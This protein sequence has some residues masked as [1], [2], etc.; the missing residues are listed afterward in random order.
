MIAHLWKLIWNRKRA[1]A[2][3]LTELLAAFLVLAGLATAGAYYLRNY[4]APLGYALEDIWAVEV[5]HGISRWEGT[6]REAVIEAQTATRQLLQTVR[7]LPD[8]VAVAGA[9]TGPILRGMRN[10]ETGDGDDMPPLGQNLERDVDSVTQDFDQVFGLTLLRGRWF[11][12]QDDGAGFRPIVINE[13]MARDYFGDQDPLGQR[14]GTTGGRRGERLPIRVIG[15]VAGYRQKGELAPPV[16]YQFFRYEPEAEFQLPYHKLFVKT[17]PGAGVAFEEALEKRLRVSA[18]REWSFTIQ[19]LADAHASVHEAELVPLKAAAIIAGF[20]ML[21][22]VLGL[23]GVL[24]QNVTQR[25]REIGLR[26]AKG[27]TRPHVYGQILGELMVMTFIAVS[28]GALLLAHVP[29]LNP[30]DDVTA[31][32]YV[33]GGLVAALVLFV[34]TALCGFYPARLAARVEPA[35]ALRSD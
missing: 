12:K 30:I 33:H 29:F 4:R 9:V 15:V 28:V 34:L 18:P 20:L 1:N 8:V 13:R 10:T 25:T 2:L 31:I 7:D 24:W 32:T 17:R 14:V 11:G 3:I 21:L 26:R 23:T 19:R 35:L 22:V 5:G 6:P 27:A 16:R